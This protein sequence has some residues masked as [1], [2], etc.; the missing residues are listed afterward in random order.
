LL[1]P[2]QTG[3]QTGK[4]RQTLQDF[5]FQHILFVYS[6]RRGVHCWV[7]DTEARKLSNEQRSAVAEYLTLVSSGAGKCRAEPW[8]RTRMLMMCFDVFVKAFERR[9]KWVSE[10]GM[11]KVSRFIYSNC[12]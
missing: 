12:M 4:H 5:G 10:K 6:G 2:K 1:D 8:L 9:S 3:K 7:C 11:F